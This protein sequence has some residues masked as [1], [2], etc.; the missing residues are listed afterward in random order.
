MT[1]LNANR[2]VDIEE[3]IV[4]STLVDGDLGVPNVG[5]SQSA[6]FDTGAKAIKYPRAVTPSNDKPEA[7][8]ASPGHTALLTLFESCWWN[9]FSRAYAAESG[10]ISESGSINITDTHDLGTIYGEFLATGNDPSI[11]QKGS[12]RYEGLRSSV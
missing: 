4:F 8:G 6:K 1:Y 2:S 10:M 3:Q 9:N 7:P 5:Q 12:E 11:G